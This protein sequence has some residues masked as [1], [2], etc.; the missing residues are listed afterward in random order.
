MTATSKKKPAKKPAK[1]TAT[2]KKPAAK[3]DEGYKGHRPGSMKEKMHQ[4]Y[5]QHG[6]EKARPLALKLGAAEGTVSTSFSQFKT[7]KGA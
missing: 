1:K 5:D 6:P 2:A 3:K 7:A 4:L